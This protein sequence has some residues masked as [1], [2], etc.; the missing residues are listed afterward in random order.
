MSTRTI[1]WLATLGVVLS[2]VPA[3]AQVLPAATSATLRSQVLGE[4]R[5]VFVAVPE[6]YTQGADRYPVVYLTDADWNFAHTRSSAQF[7]ARNRI[8]PEVIVVGITNPDRVRDLY[9]T[10]ADFTL[11]GRTIRFP[12]SGNADQFLAFIERELIP[13]VERTYRASGLRIL[14]GHSAGGNFALHAMRTKPDLF[15]AVIAASPWLA[16]DEERELKELIP[17]V[18]SPALRIRSLFLSHTDDIDTMK[19][20]V[21]RLVAALRRRGDSTVHWATRGYPYETHNTDAHQ[22]FFDGLRT[23]F[24]GYDYPRDPNTNRLVGSLDNMK[25]HYARLGRRLGIPFDPPEAIVNELGYRYLAADTVQLAVAAFRFNVDRHPE[26]ANAWDSLGD[27]LERGGHR[28][29]AL[30][31]YRKAVALAE[32]QGHPGVETFRQNAARLAAPR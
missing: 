5:T 8:M 30:E 28:V 1:L 31:S 19:P 3:G 6:S 11:N 13:W 16:W 10:R 32:R 14:A 21:D 27:G 17:F 9:A 7:L 2:S 24:S 18:A 23:V 29:E 22:G 4:D 12:T 20:N 26:S 15:L 25:V